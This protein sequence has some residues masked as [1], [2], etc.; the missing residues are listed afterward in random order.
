MP[1]QRPAADSE[2]GK[3]ES[4]GDQSTG[5]KF[6]CR[7]HFIHVLL[8]DV[9]VVIIVI[10]VFVYYVDMRNVIYTNKQDII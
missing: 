8:H 10:I 2:F 1:A 9:I 5:Q 7:S 3:E 6:S 4:L